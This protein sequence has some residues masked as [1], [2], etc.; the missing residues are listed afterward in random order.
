MSSWSKIINWKFVTQGIFQEYII[1]CAS[2]TISKYTC[3]MSLKQKRNQRTH[4]IMVQRLLASLIVKK[5]IESDKNK[6]RF[7]VKNN[8]FSSEP[9]WCRVWAKEVDSWTI[10][11]ELK[12]K[13]AF[14]GRLCTYR[15]WID[16]S[17]FLQFHTSSVDASTARTQ[18][19]GFPFRPS[20]PLSIKSGH[21][22]RKRTS[23]RT[24]HP[25]LAE[26]IG[27]LVERFELKGS[28]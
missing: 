5:C 17:G 20:D 6:I 23:T 3:I 25:F 2:G 28:K 7:T 26:A 10:F 4:G 11:H 13:W 24:L 14:V 21:S 15:Y 9:L 22:G 8:Y 18:L 12:S 1:T 19:S 27:N 16:S